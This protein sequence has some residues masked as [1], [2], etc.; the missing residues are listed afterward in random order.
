MPPGKRHSITYPPVTQSTQAKDHLH[1]TH[2]F[3]TLHEKLYDYA[4]NQVITPTFLRKIGISFVV[5]DE[6]EKQEY[7]IH[8]VRHKA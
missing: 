3:H 1:P 4:E 7:A 2:H 8:R 5:K 6:E